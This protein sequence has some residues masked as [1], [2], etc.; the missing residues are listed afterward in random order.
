MEWC[1]KA[2]ENGHVRAKC[3]LTD[4]YVKK[5]REYDIILI[6]K[7]AEN[8]YADAQSLL[9]YFYAT[10]KK[11]FDIATEWYKKAADQ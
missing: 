9:G 2:A 10:K 1:Q 3:I 6:K 7:A 11:D 8:G 5:L 4:F